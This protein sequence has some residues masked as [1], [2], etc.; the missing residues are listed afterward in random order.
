MFEFTE[1]IYIDAAPPRVWDTFSDVE[2]WWPPSNPEHI[3]IQVEARPIAEGTAVSFE[4]KVAGIPG[5]A[6]GYIT[7]L[8]PGE[9]V[10]WAGT[11]R[12]RYKHLI[13][14]TIREGV[15]WT[16]TP[17]GNGT[18]LS[19]RVWASFPDTLTGRLLE[20]YARRFVDVIRQDRTHARQELE[21]LKQ[22]IEGGGR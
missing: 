20:W 22:H 9:R 16:L 15:S 2:R 7:E 11:A 17:D 6:R 8:W 5:R 13:P 4:E 14:F 19:A 10:T 21:W 1:S 3:S 12:Y 18:R